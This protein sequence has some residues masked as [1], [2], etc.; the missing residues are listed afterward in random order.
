MIT[1]ITGTPGAGKTAW[2]LDQAVKLAQKDNRAVYIAGVRGLQPERMPVEVHVLESGAAWFETPASS[3]IVLDEVQEW[4]R[5][6][7]HGS[8]VPIGAQR[9]ERHRHDGY[10][11]FLTTQDP[12]LVDTHVRKLCGRHVHLQALPTGGSATIYDYPSVQS[13]PTEYFAK[14]AAQSISAWRRPLEVF[15]WYESTSE[16]TSTHQRRIP[17]GAILKLLPVLIVLAWLGHSAWSG[18]GIFGFFTS[19]PASETE[20]VSVSDAV[21]SRPAAAGL[22]TDFRTAA[23]VVDAAGWAAHWEPRVTNVPWSAPAYDDV[24]KALDFPRPY[25]VIMHDDAGGVADCICHTQQG[26][27]LGMGESYCVGFVRYG[28]WDPSQERR[29]GA[30]GSRSRAPSRERA[31]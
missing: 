16:V 22:T 27:R 10:D 5:V 8:E 25:C 19:K 28:F 3:I 13:R 2:A 15:E 6:R 23:P 31:L 1:L 20:L 30:S 14:Q 18:T 4:Y 21:L 26:T 29:G 7:R 17:G 9:M 11:L 24:F 12:T